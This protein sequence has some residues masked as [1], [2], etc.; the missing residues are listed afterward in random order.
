MPSPFQFPSEY[1]LFDLEFTAWEGSHKRNW[2]GE[3]EHREIIQIGAVKVRAETSEEIAFFNEYV[4]PTLNPDLSD[5]ITELTGITQSDIESKGLS[6]P[7]ALARFATFVGT[8]PMYCWGRDTQ[9]LL[10]NCTLTHIEFPIPLTQC[11]DLRPLVREQF[12]AADVHIDEYTSGTLIQAFSSAPSLR[13]HD[14]L[15]DVRNLQ[16]ALRELQKRQV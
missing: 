12:A 11:A 3:N 16:D 4:R 10:E 13:A 7:D 2:S 5:Y 9:V 14:A 1:I 6:F 8:T 15:N